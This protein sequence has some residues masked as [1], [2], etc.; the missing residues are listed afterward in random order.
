MIAHNEQVIENSLIER[1]T[2][3]GWTHVSLS[4]GDDL[5]NN[6]KTQLGVFNK[7]FFSDD[8]F[9]KIKNHLAKGTLF[10]KAKTLRDRFVL[11]RDNG[12]KET[13][14][15]LNSDEWC[16]NLY[17]V[18]NQVSISEDG[19]RKRY[20]V[21]L[22]INGLPL[23]QIEL[24]RKGIEIK[25]AFNQIRDYQKKSYSKYA[26]LFQYVQVFMISNGSNTRYYANG[27]DVTFK[28]TIKWSNKD[29]TKIY[30]A[31]MEFAEQ[32]LDK[33]HFSKMI[34]KYM[35]ISEADRRLMILRPYQYYAAE[36]I[37]DKV[38]TNSGNGCIWHTTGSGKTLTSFK[39]AQNIALLPKVDKVVFVV[40]RK[41]LDT[42]TLS[43]FDNFESGAF[44]KSENTK[45]LV[46]NLRSK[47][48][49][50]RM[51]ITTI[52]KLNSAVMR[53]PELLEELRL[54]RVVFIFDEC[55]R[56]QFGEM[57]KRIEDFFAK[58]Q[59]FGFTG[60]PIFEE[61]SQSGRKTVDV[62]GEIL[63]QYIITDAIQDQN[64]LP[65]SVEYMKAHHYHGGSNLAVYDAS[66]SKEMKA[67][68]ASPKRRKAIVDWIVKNHARKTFNRSYTS[69]FC[70]SSIPELLEYYRLFKMERKRGN[71]SLNVSTIFSY[72]PQGID[73]EADGLLG[74]VVT[75][76][77]ET[78]EERLQECVNDY[79][80]MFGT[81]KDLQGASGYD[82]YYRDIITRM[83][84]RDYNGFKKSEGI[85]IL[86]VVD[87]FLT[88]FD[89]RKLN[90]LYVDKNLKYHG[91]IQAFS[92][93]NR[94][95]SIEKSFGN[96]VCFRDLRAQEKAALALFGDDNVHDTVFVGDYTQHLSELVEAIDTL[97]S[98]VPTPQDVDYLKG[99]IAKIEFVRAMRDVIRLEKQISVFSEY[100]P[101]ASGLSED[102]LNDY[103]GKY[104]D[105][106]E[107]PKRS[108]DIDNSFEGFDFEIEL[109]ENVEIDYDY[110]IS[111]LDHQR[112][113]K[114]GSPK[115]DI[116]KIIDRL[117]SNNENLRP[118]KPLYERFQKEIIPRLA[119]DIRTEDA[120]ND[121]IGQ[122]QEKEFLAMCKKHNLDIPKTKRLIEDRLVHV[123][124]VEDPH[125]TMKEI[126]IRG[127]TGWREL[128]A[129]YDNAFKNLMLYVE[130]FYGNKILF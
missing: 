127:L 60:T 11:L 124:E 81:K 49:K 110:I 66:K 85:D 36:A 12:D 38:K 128:N 78:Y 5:W 96:I 109:L 88:G 120:L 18:A 71:H 55:H 50:H 68:Y 90:T 101:T 22:L 42:Q 16:K 64:V 14:R 58:S 69:I 130:K 102:E 65:F 2:Q 20:D 107:S 6:V 40:D 89:V 8:E 62:F 41:D 52:Q 129:S 122:E 115:K 126:V 34:A 100:T 87:M 77:P 75:V 99:N 63:H 121:F 73:D 57:Q 118:M 37:L 98:I 51:V 43:E 30:S 80:V 117:I 61:N 119:D 48:N 3:T 45:E 83:K 23:G 79:N 21:T 112:F 24:K 86:L 53:T 76:A 72:G 9:K 25:A 111:L 33:C 13:I 19:L 94:T 92:R 7:T 46:S 91:L 114:K 84:S 4:G 10:D 39:A 70:V 56:S 103:K 54:G 125:P 28:H 105:I 29:G 113:A 35:V 82:G 32:F 1:L 116:A 31:L 93:T 44:S 59:R 26:G 104:K 108:E 106:S 47:Q 97:R 27:H 67:F 17:Q 15:F 123:S 95:V 74:E